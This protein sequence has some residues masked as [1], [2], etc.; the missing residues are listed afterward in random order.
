MNT[1]LGC[2]INTKLG[3]NVLRRWVG[4]L[5]IIDWIRLKP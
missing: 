1:K 2:K 4:K 3:C 5:N